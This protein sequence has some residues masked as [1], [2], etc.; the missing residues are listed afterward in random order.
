MASINEKM[1]KVPYPP[2]VKNYGKG[3]FLLIGAACIIGGVLLVFK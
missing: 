2:P 1:L 3:F